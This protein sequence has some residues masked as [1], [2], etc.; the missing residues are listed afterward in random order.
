M[1]RLVKYIGRQNSDSRTEMGNARR[2]EATWRGR[3]EVANP[4]WPCS[5]SEMIDIHE[6]GGR[7]NS[8][9]ARFETW[10]RKLSKAWPCFAKRRRIERPTKLRAGRKNRL[11]EGRR[12]SFRHVRQRTVTL[13]RFIQCLFTRGNNG[14]GRFACD[15]YRFWVIDDS[16]RLRSVHLEGAFNTPCAGPAFHFPPLVY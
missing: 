7:S 9:R 11:Q 8:L 14:N 12:I 13:G 6:P 16:F 4:F 2:E 10:I 1:N 5:R 3:S 15:Q